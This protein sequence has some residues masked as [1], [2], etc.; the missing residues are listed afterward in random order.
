VAWPLQGG[1]ALDRG[2]A[3]ANG[4]AANVSLGPG[5]LAYA[6]PGACVSVPGWTAPDPAFTLVVSFTAPALPPPVYTLWEAGS[7]ASE[8][9][10]YVANG[11]LSASYGAAYA[12]GGASVAPGAT[13]RAGASCTP[14][15][16][17]VFT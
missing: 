3:P 15:S 9:R 6:D 12:T 1:S 5:G 2:L 10:L 16:C 14:S 4:L 11:T 13:V 8:A 17:L 7:G